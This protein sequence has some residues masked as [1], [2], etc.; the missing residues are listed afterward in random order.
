MLI[1]NFAQYNE[2]REIL[3]ITI[4]DSISNSRLFGKLTLHGGTGLRLCYFLDRFSDDLDF[5]GLITDEELDELKDIVYSELLKKIAHDIE[6]NS[7][8]KNDVYQIITKVHPQ[9]RS[10]RLLKVNI[11]ISPI[12]PLTREFMKAYSKY[13]SNLSVPVY[14]ESLP[15][16]LA[17]KIVAIG[18]RSFTENTPFRGRDLWDIYWMIQH[19]IKLS[20]DMVFSKLQSYNATFNQFNTLIRKKFDFLFT[21]KGI[22]SF[23]NEIDR[24]LDD[25]NKSLILEDDSIKSILKVVQMQI[26]INLNS[27]K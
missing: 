4:L 1:F 17:D 16:I 2:E 27:N 13:Y 14:V 15:E 23:K 20:K 3:Q 25:S 11:T 12:Q 18:L 26:D 5:R 24:F 7:N 9:N 22:Q 6:V 19:N 10:K 8:K 21:K